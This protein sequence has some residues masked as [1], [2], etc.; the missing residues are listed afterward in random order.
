[1][2]TPLE[3][4]LAYIGRGWNP[5][6]VAF[7]EKRPTAGE[8][9]QNVRITERNA[10]QY[11]N[12]A[13]Q[14]LGVQLGPTSNNLRDVDL[15][16][17]EAA[18]AAPYF[19]PKTG[20]IFGRASAR[21]THWL[22]YADDFGERLDTAALQYRD[23]SKKMLVELRVGEGDK[24]AQTVFPGST[25]ESGEEIRWGL[26]GEPAKV[27]GAELRRR[28]EIVATIALLA[29]SWPELGARHEARL[30]IGGML[31]RAG[32]KLQEAD[33]FAQA[34]KAAVG[35]DSD[36]FRPAV[37]SS[38]AKV[39]ANQPA[40]GFTTVAEIFGKDVGEKVRI[41]LRLGYTDAGGV[42]DGASSPEWPPLASPPSRKMRLEWF[43][44]AS[45]L[46]LSAASIPLI[47]DVLDEGALSVIYGESNSGKTFITLDM[48]MAVATGLPWNGKATKRG[49]IAYIAAEGGKRIQRRF[50]A[51]QKRHH[52]EHG[53]D[54]PE[55]LLTLVRF[56]ID[57]RSNDANLKELVALIRSAEAETGEKCVWI[58]VDT[59]SRALAG[60][61]ENSPVDMG[62]IVV[63]AIHCCARRQIPKSKS[64]PER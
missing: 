40:T 48:A 5:V 64:L 11:F 8:G 27:D 42:G 6:P 22:F 10:T 13:P 29:R 58:I 44:E 24:G 32:W 46:A 52:T 61:D 15:D 38:F 3:T 47:A 9:W 7:R 62:R 33:L 18:A 30:A 63:A 16:C 19:L 50:A 21:N 51:L 56:P 20:A 4:A 43:S 39:T 1:M 54:A 37:K 2:T 34:L 59:L 60:G 23:P 53:D 57:L 28:V 26:D 49:L 35:S 45:A 41:W 31:A 17:P 55:P 25:H 36:D 12:G 14:N